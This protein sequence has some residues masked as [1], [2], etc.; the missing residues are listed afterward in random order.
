M[1]LLF[2]QSSPILAAAT[3][4]D[5]TQST[6]ANSTTENKDNI[7]QIVTQENTTS[8][9]P[10]SSPVEVNSEDIVTTPSVQTTTEEPVKPSEGISDSED[11]N[12]T[13]P[14]SETTT[15][16][17]TTET[18]PSSQQTSESNSASS[19]SSS[20][21]VTS[22]S[23]NNSSKPS[24]SNSSS[25]TS[26]SKTSATSSTTSP[27]DNKKPNSNNGQPS[28]GS[29]KNQQKPNE[30]TQQY[31]QTQNV[32]P[33]ITGTITADNVSKDLLVDSITKSNLNGFVLPL[34]SSLDDKAQAAI[35]V[36]ALKQLGKPYNAD[37][38]KVQ[39]GNEK[40][41]SFNNQ[42]FPNYVYN[43]VFGV[44]L[45]NNLDEI[46]KSGENVDIKKAKIGDILVWKDSNKVG[47]YLGNNKVILS[48]DFPE[49]PKKAE[50]S[51]EKNQN[52]SDEKLEERPIEKSGVKILTISTKKAS[53]EKDSKLKYDRIVAPDYAVKT[54]E[55]KKLNSYGESLVKN[56]AASADFK[57][58]QLTRDFVESIGDSA[59][60]LGQKYDVFASVMIA[61]AILESGS[62]TSGL[63]RAPYNN[64][65]GVKG[66]GGQASAVFTTQEDNGN[67]QLYSI[68]APFRVYSSASQSLE[69]YVSLIREG[70]SGNSSIY[71][72]AWRSEAKNYLQATEHLTGKYAT[73]TQYSNKLNSIIAAYN[74]TRFDDPKGESGVS[75]Q[76]LDGIPEQYKDAIDFPEYNGFN[77]NLSGSYPVGQCTWYVYN[78]IKQLGGSVGETMGN[79]GDWGVTGLARGYEVS[80][81]PE[82][83]YAISFKPG[84]A[85]ADG[86]YG[87]VAFVEAVTADGILISESNVLGLGKVS[88]RIIPNDIALSSGVTYIAPK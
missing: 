61:Q 63:S 66:G 60:E 39:D 59:R 36:E 53:K 81:T 82:A 34:L 64:L 76:S 71:K 2:S 38:D 43:K 54:S 45:G 3:T 47:I 55:D 87:H 67:G 79:G 19:T 84:V 70:I 29:D 24:T 6:V 15:T 83:G 69:D 7:D 85:G 57:P 73:D 18:S 58:T 41:K 10:I 23:S 27:S 56:Y 78:R 26:S 31:S 65:F 88:Y 12:I 52:K 22:G 40:D 30:S 46:N 48:D 14:S 20:S 50:S 25:A 33:Y 1:L 8:E 32:N 35:I 13:E 77:Y 16:V 9:Q 4:V 5:E 49:E 11:N 62:G 86:F 80:S 44:A 74:L 42:Y 28:T 21:S 68:Q 37:A 51:I 75:I 17:E 72:G